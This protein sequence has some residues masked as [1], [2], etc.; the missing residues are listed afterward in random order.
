MTESD[1]LTRGRD[2]FERLA[3]KT[4]YALFAKAAAEEPLEPTDLVRMATAAALSGFLEEAY[5]LDSRAYREFLSRGQLASA[6][7]SA[8]WLCMRYRAFGDAV[9]ANG[10]LARARRAL[11]ECGE[12]CVER[13]Y[14]ILPAALEAAERGEFTLALETFERARAIGQRFQ[15]KDL[16]AVAQLGLGSCRLRSGS[17]NEGLSQLDEIMLAVEGREVSP[18]VTGIL[19]C[20]VIDVCHEVFDLQRAQAWTNALTDWCSAQPDLVPFQGECQ[21]HRARVLQ[22]HGAWRAALDVTQ[23]VTHQRLR[24]SPTQAVG[25]A[26]YQTAELHRLQGQ[27]DQ[28]EEAYRQ[29]SRLGHV[30]EP[31]LAQLR[32]AQGQIDSAV[33]GVSR[34][35]DQARGRNERS[36]LLPAYVEIMLA[37]GDAASA[38]AGAEELSEIAAEVGTPFLRACAEYATGAVLLSSGDA[39]GGQDVLRDACASWQQLDAPYEAARTREL[40]GLASVAL[41]DADRASLELDAAAWTYRQLGAQ[42]DLARI[43]RHPDSSAPL[44]AGG[45]TQ[46]EVEVL[47]LVAAGKTNRSIATEL[48]VSEKTVARHVANIFVKLNLSTRS[49]A[50]AYAYEHKIV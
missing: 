13:G 6:A 7:R 29:S 23:S 46:R 2:A 18:L 20:S 45:L 4:A 43:S 50:T 28:A 36:L 49:A 48:V 21:V 42:P 5:E 27:F 38:R 41:G 12:E 14:V 32:L 19:Y 35:L 10:W 47:R 9:R 34:A 3:W 33:A 39:R 15:E 8:F 40:I 26:W 31:G 16:I 22:L 17:P 44:D 25:L 1:T 30:P 37:A 24:R 11:E